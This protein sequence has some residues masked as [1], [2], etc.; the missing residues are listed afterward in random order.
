MRSNCL[1]QDLLRQDQNDISTILEVELNISFLKDG[2]RIIIPP[3]IAVDPQD[4]SCRRLK[5]IYSDLYMKREA[6]LK[7]FTPIYIYAID[8]MG[9]NI[10]GESIIS[11]TVSNEE[12]FWTTFNL[13]YMAGGN[14]SDGSDKGQVMVEMGGK[15]GDGPAVFNG[16][17]SRESTD[18]FIIVID[19]MFGFASAKETF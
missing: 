3:D 10:F 12:D 19:K 15:D 17:V 4:T 9:P 13:Y 11:S 7:N 16:E 18:W 6:I 8:R 5:E 2:L 14:T 1:F